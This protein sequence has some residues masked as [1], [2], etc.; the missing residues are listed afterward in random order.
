[1]KRNIAIYEGSCCKN[2]NTSGAEKEVL[3]GKMKNMNIFLVLRGKHSS[4]CYKN[5]IA[6]GNYKFGVVMKSVYV[7]KSI[8]F[9][10][11]LLF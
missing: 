2:K 7:H 3:T 5:N 10:D 9:L 1:M 4:S 8:Y 6:F 11:N